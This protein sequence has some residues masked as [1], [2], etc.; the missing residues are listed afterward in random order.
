[1]TVADKTAK[2]LYGS[3][4]CCH[5]LYCNVLTRSYWTTSQ[6]ALMAAR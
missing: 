3:T 5:T 6:C 4:L 1:M 2:K